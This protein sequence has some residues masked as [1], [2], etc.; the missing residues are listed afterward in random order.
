[1]RGPLYSDSVLARSGSSVVVIAAP[2]PAAALPS[3]LTSWAVYAGTAQRDS[4]TAEID[5][6][7][8]WACPGGPASETRHAREMLGERM[9]LPLIHEGSGGIEGA[10]PF[11]IDRL[12]SFLAHSVGVEPDACEVARFDLERCRRAWRELHGVWFADVLEH[13]LRHHGVKRRAPV[14]GEGAAA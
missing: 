4:R 8:V 3:A 6:V 13:A 12:T 7:R 11:A 5:D 1:M 10:M 14:S 9:I 2:L